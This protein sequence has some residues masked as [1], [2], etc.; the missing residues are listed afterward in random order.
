MQSVLSLSPHFCLVAT[1]SSF[2]V[3]GLS[4]FKGMGLSG[5]WLAYWNSPNTSYGI[6]GRLAEQNVGEWIAQNT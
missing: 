6:R 2:L 1:Q 5:C 4:Q 3:A